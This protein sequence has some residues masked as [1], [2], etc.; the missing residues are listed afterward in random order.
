MKII[1]FLFLVLSQGSIAQNDTIA[2][3][4]Q[5]VLI[6][7]SSRITAMINADVDKLEALL[8]DDLTYAHTT[9]WTETKSGY[10]ETIKSKRINYIS[11]IPR[12]VNIRI[13]ENTA[14]LTGMVKVNLGRTDFEIK[15][16]E[17]Q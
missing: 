1:G 9:G 7:Q 4:E 13:F 16:L 2:I 11:F 17:V 6:A 12:N 10:L 15:F 5:E 8:S 3:L 14:V